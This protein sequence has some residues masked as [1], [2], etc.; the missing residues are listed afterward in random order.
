MLSQVTGQLFIL[1]REFFVM[2][3]SLPRKSMKVIEML[4]PPA[5][6]ASFFDL[7][8]FGGRFR[9]FALIPAV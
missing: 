1:C 2:K 6:Q 5:V 9:N 7:S 3:S 4:Q 8:N